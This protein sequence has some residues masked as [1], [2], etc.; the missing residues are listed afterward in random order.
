[1][2]IEVSTRLLRYKTDSRSQETTDSQ[3]VLIGYSTMV[4]ALSLPPKKTCILIPNSHSQKF[5]TIVKGCQDKPNNYPPK[6]KADQYLHLSID[7]Q[8][9]P[10]TKIY[11]I[12][13]YSTWQKC[14]HMD[15]D[16]SSQESWR[17]GTPLIL[18][19][20]GHTK[21]YTFVSNKSIRGLIRCRK[22]FG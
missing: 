11:Q 9:H 18:W 1:M 13:L 10:A 19:L 21:K 7:D 6:D 8:I 14:T 5:R 16:C 2:D 15:I 17:A 20:I 3:K 12:T 22:G 4:I